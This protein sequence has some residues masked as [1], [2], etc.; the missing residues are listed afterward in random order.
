M[1]ERFGLEASISMRQYQQSVQTFDEWV[2]NSDRARPVAFAC[3]VVLPYTSVRNE[4]WDEGGGPVG[5]Y[6]SFS[7]TNVVHPHPLTLH[8]EDMERFQRAVQVLDLTPSAMLSIPQNFSAWEPE[9]REAQSAGRHLLVR[10][11]ACNDE[12]RAGKPTDCHLQLR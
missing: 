10:R 8:S 4:L 6:Q 1:L 7:E 12:A 11:K 9:N 5:R 3:N 2:A